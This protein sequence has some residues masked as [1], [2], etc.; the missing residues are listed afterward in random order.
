MGHSHATARKHANQQNWHDC[1]RCG[2]A[3]AS[4]HVVHARV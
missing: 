4:A 1:R 3:T 2:E